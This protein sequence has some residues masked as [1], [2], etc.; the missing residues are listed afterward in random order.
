MADIT[1]CANKKCKIKESCYRY[2]ANDGYWQSYANFKDGKT[3][4]DKKECEHYLFGKK[5]NKNERRRTS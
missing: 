1:K 3:I 4:K 2:T 5:G